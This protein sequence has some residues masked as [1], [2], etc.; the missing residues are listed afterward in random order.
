M[1]VACDASSPAALPSVS[2]T[3]ALKPFST[4][5][6]TLA[7]LYRDKIFFHARNRLTQPM[8]RHLSAYF[9]PELK[10][11]L[12]HHHKDVELW[13]IKNKDSDLKLPVSAGPI[14]L[15]NYEGADSFLIGDPSIRD[16]LAEV[17]IAFTLKD[18]MGVLE[19]ENTALLKRVG[20]VWLLDDIVFES[21]NG[22]AYTLRDRVKLVQ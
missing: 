7:Q 20:D 19:W 16:K 21:D 22:E 11:H 14:F 12:E 4:P 6:E 2:D 1:I 18:A 15:S 5:A 17:K 3:N 10:K 13:L 9:T 8:I